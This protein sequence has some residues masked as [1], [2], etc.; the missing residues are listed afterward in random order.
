MREAIAIVLAGL[1]AAHPG[2]AR[3]DPE[4]K[5]DRRAALL[6]ALDSAALDP[7]PATPVA[8]RDLWDHEDD[9]KGRRVTVEGRIVRRFSQPAIGPFPALTETW[10][11][12]GGDNPL[13]LVYPVP[14]PSSS[15]APVG[16]R[17]R[18]A[19]WSLGHVTFAASDQPRLAP[20]IAGPEPPARLDRPH[21][22][23]QGAEPAL[24]W[25]WIAAGAAVI[26]F[27]AALG[28]IAVSRRHLVRETELPRSSPFTP[29]PAGNSEHPDG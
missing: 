16:A 25:G 20:L 27:L 23:T 21:G 18:F 19:G 13:C 12:T 26:G 11:L 6:Q 1:I 9:W 29:G 22:D 15:D 4:P 14:E 5:P 8:F 17:V 7:T 24:P 2:P 10:I 3:D 28:S